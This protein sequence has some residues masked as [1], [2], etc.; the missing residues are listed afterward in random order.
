MRRKRIAAWVEEGSRED[1]VGSLLVWVRDLEPSPGNPAGRAPFLS[2]M[3]VEPDARRKGVGTAL[4]EAAVQWCR[5]GG[6][7][8]VYGMPVNH[9]RKLLRG[10]GF[11]TME[12]EM[13]LQF[14]KKVQH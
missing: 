1:A 10:M 14:G 12:G 9:A 3:Y 7:P 11:E 5:K 2:T 4:V 13:G 8:Y 6:F